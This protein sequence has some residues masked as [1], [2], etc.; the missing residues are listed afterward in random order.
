VDGL[1]AAAQGGVDLG[2]L[3]LGA[4]EADLQA[5]DL[6]EPSLTLGLGDPVVQVDPDLL[7]AGALGWVRS[8]E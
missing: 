5:L 6:A 4:G 2:E 7:Q 3:V 8:Q 1:L